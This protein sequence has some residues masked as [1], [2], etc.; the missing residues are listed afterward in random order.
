MVSLWC[1][2]K[3]LTK[4]KNSNWI[5]VCVCVCMLC[6]NTH[7]CIQCWRMSWKLHFTQSTSFGQTKRQ[8]NDVAGSCHKLRTERPTVTKVDQTLWLLHPNIISLHAHTHTHQYSVRIFALVNI[9]ESN[10]RCHVT[11]LRILQTLPWP[12]EQNVP[13][14][15][16]FQMFLPD[17]VNQTVEF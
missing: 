5:L 12:V 1:D 16:V 8:W 3:I 14:E 11:V 13:A 9:S 17:V 7:I 10:Q 4:C 15:D 2:S 6:F